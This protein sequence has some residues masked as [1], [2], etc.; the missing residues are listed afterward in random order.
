MPIR[1]IVSLLA[2]F[3]FVSFD[4]ATYAQN[5]TINMSSASQTTYANGLI[6]L[7][8]GE[9]R[10]ARIVAEDAL[11]TNSADPDLHELLGHACVGLQDFDRAIESFTQ[12]IHF[13]SRRFFSYNNRGGLYSLR[14]DW[15]HAIDDYGKA[16]AIDPDRPEAYYGRANAYLS[17]RQYANAKV[18]FE[19]FYTRGGGILAA[20]SL[21]QILSTCPD[22]TIRDG[23]RAIK[24][25]RIICEATDYKEPLFLNVL[26]SSLAE[27]S[28]WIEAIHRTEQALKLAERKGDTAGVSCVGIRMRL[29]LYQHHEP[30]RNL[31]QDHPGDWSS[32]SPFEA[33]LYG[34][35]KMDIKDYEGAIK[36]LQKSVSLN[37]NLASAH[38]ALGCAMKQLGH[39]DKAIGYFNR[40]LELDSNNLEAFADRAAAF[41][42]MGKSR[43]AISDANK[44]LVLN[45]RNFL[46]RL[47]HA[48]ALGGV[49]GV[50]EVD[51]ALK[52]LEN[53][54]QEY[55]DHDQIYF[56]RG[57]CYLQ[58]GRY[59]DAVGEFDKAIRR[60]GNSALAYSK[61]A[62]ALSRLGNAKEA[63]RD[64][65]ECIRLAPTLRTQTEA[66]MKATKVESYR[67]KTTE[68]M[69]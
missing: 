68:R 21:A 28:Q 20:Y 57:D 26:A 47:T 51:Q 12:A 54:S 9:Y 31:P 34:C 49:G 45:E 13:G 3:I 6:H 43:E 38:Y 4:D 63:K 64:L 22:V 48:W 14:K 2:F 46:A 40:C 44:A 24:Y 42:I 19:A 60:N 5:N 53:L 58:H 65:E 30:Y 25:A 8:R 39:A 11:R 33:L 18:D 10:E 29:E 59:D 32:S 37:P 67:E 35:A 17:V 66:R 27:T 50:G 61:R 41:C 16:I 55:P 7:Q 36:D 62:I 23:R 69:R 56:V 52:E 15:L 1:M